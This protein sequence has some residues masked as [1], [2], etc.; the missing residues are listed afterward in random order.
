MGRLPALDGLRAIAILIVMVSHAGLG[1]IVPGN[2]GVTIFFFL[3]GYL[4][5]TLMVSEWDRTERLDFSAFY[6]RRVVRIIPPMVVAIGIT[7]VLALAGYMRPMNYS[8]LTWDFL[9]LTNYASL[10]GETSNIPIPLWSLDVEEHFYLLFPLLFAFVRRRGQISAVA[11]ACVLLC[12][13]VLLVRMTHAFEA[14]MN[15][16]IYYWSHTRIDSI[17]YG[18]IL[19]CWNNPS[20]KGRTFINGHIVP[21]FVGAAL[22]LATFIIRDPVFRETLRY[23]LQGVGL[24]LIFN[25][26][27][28]NQGIV[29]R[30][31]AHPVLKIIADLSYF[32]YLI[33][34]PMVVFVSHFT[35]SPELLYAGAFALSF[36]SAALV[37]QHIELPL[38]RW[39]K[40]I[41]LKPNV[42]VSIP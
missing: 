24:F 27:L 4:I 11:L 13:L 21:A 5:T 28:R 34:L 15:R 22:I 10:F 16:N 1:H 23:S 6:L 7:T 14:E 32:L 35:T 29:S 36:L 8:G 33:H 17:I 2:F 12:V 3:S 31:L 37:R 42:K 25:Y 40:R 39:R 9:F 20:L 18:C 26:A 30:L 19:A 41:E 38:L